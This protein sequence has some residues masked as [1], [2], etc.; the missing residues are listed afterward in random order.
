MAAAGQMAE[1]VAAF[2]QSLELLKGK[3]AY[4]LACTQRELA[5]TLETVIVSGKTEILD[6]IPDAQ[7]Y[8]ADLSHQASAMFERL[9]IVH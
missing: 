7:S 1:A 8:A 4:A 2:Q 3:D 9:Q 6:T 5:Q